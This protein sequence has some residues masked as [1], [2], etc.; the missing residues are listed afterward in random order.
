[1]DKEKGLIIIEW[2]NRPSE[3]EF[4]ITDNGPGIEPQYF[5]KVFQIFQTLKPRDEVE[6]VGIGLAIIRKIITK[7]GGRIW[8]KSGAGV[9]LIVCFT[10]PKNEK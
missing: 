9:G 10:I 1:M 4:S 3:Y 8:M 7:Y 6:G 2:A 5:D